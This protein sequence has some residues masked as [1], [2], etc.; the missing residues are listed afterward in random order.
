M[1]ILKLG[2]EKPLTKT[3]FFKVR[4]FLNGDGLEL[5]APSGNVNILTLSYANV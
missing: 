4:L 2:K 3:F 1:Y 5:S